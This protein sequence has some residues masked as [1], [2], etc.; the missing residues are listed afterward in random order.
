M[1]EATIR[2]R[3]TDRYAIRHPFACAGM[4]FAG[5][6]PALAIAVTQAGGIGALGVGFTPPEVLRARTRAIRSAVDGPF[7]HQL[8]HLL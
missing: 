8:H 4:A 7:Q 1:T 6:T 2:T 3:F 5:M